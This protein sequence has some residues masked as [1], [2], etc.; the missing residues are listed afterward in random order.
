VFFGY[1]KQSCAVNARTKRLTRQ[2]YS[3]SAGSKLNNG[4][5]NSNGTVKMSCPF[6]LA[7]TSSPLIL[8]RPI[9][10]FRKSSASYTGEKL[11]RV[12]A[13]GIGK[14]GH[15]QGFLTHRGHIEGAQTFQ[16]RNNRP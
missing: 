4:S 13:Q 2:N 10:P 3:P 12:E 5:R 11:F 15:W 16:V 9:T 1:L 8:S 6:T 14:A 7:S